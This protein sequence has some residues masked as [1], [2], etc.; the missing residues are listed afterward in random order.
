VQAVS[1]CRLS[2]EDANADLRRRKG[3]PLQLLDGTPAFSGT[4]EGEI[5]YENQEAADIA[6]R[7]YSKE[8]GEPISIYTG[9]TGAGE[10]RLFEPR[11]S[12]SGGT[13]GDTGTAMF[14]ME[15]GTDGSPPRATIY[16]NQAMKAG[17]LPRVLQHELDEIAYIAATRPN[18][19]VA[20]ILDS[21]GAPKAVYGRLARDSRSTER[22]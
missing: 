17:D 21:P 10:E 12:V 22:R 8:A 4:R 6:A 1:E 5:A 13:W 19:G 3:V 16:I 11:S 18:A 2:R 9:R 14:L 7:V 15:P 20:V